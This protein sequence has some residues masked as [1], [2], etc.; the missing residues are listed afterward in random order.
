MHFA[1]AQLVWKRKPRSYPN[2][3][4]DF[5]LYKTFTSNNCQI[6]CSKQKFKS[7]AP[8]NEKHQRR[9]WRL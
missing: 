7:K 5:N 3:L 8:T 1:I 6:K 9:F 4:G 2:E